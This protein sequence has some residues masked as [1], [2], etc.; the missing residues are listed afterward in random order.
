MY[1]VLIIFQVN[2]PRYRP[3][4]P[5]QPVQR[6]HDDFIMRA[7]GALHQA[8]FL[9][10]RLYIVKLALLADSLLSGLVTPNTRLNIDR[11]ALY[12]VFFHEPRFLQAHLAS[13]CTTSG[14]GV[15]AQHVFVWGKRSL[16]NFAFQ[17]IWV[18]AITCRHTIHGTA[19]CLSENQC[20]DCCSCQEV[21]SAT[22]LVP[23]SLLGGVCLL[24]WKTG[25]GS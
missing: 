18:S 14:Y 22:S 5:D 10:S 17:D 11:M 15:M 20:S 4:Q 2:G 21:H 8:R 25:L 19:A 1:S 23:D 13:A 7:P 9:A 16:W 12:I 24:R 3:A 6:P